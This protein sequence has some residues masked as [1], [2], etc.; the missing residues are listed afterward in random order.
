MNKI[1]FKY[2]DRIYEGYVYHI[3]GDKYYV[4][5]NNN[6]EHLFDAQTWIVEKWQ[7]I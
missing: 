6:W 4:S 3:G 1:K 2:A 5:Q 7:I